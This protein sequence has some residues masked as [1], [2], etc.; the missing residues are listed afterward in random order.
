MQVNG[1]VIHTSSEELLEEDGMK[2]PTLAQ[3]NARAS[4]EAH[5]VYV[6]GTRRKRTP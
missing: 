3:L 4:K 1:N 5:K 2:L 6:P